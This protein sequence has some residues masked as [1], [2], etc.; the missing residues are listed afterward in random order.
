MHF[1]PIQKLFE[2]PGSRPRTSTECPRGD[3]DALIGC[4]EVISPLH[5]STTTRGQLFPAVVH[6]HETDVFRFGSS[7]VFEATAFRQ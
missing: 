5:L 4:C 7:P 6:L 3:N 1:P 2:H